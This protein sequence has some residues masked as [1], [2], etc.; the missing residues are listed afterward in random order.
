MNCLS[1]RDGCE[2][3]QPDE[4]NVSHH[5]R[6]ESCATKKT[7]DRRR[8][9]ARRGEILGVKEI[10]QI[11]FPDQRLDTVTL[12][13]SHYP[14]GKRSPMSSGRILCIASMAETLL[15]I[16]SCSFQAANVAF[17]PLDGWIEDVY[18][19]YTAR[20]TEW[21]GVPR[22]F[23]PDTWIDITDTLEKKIEAFL[24]YH[25]EVRAYRI[26]GLRKRWS[27][28]QPLFGGTSAPWKRLRRLMTVRSV[29]R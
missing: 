27:M 16:I 20:S 12:T 7:W 29:K 17:R 15:W 10:R 25:S 5:V 13:E 22:T 19:F 18:A 23:T 8:R 11:G 28:R 9:S 6:G 14:A 26:P 1:R 21:G 4:I 3:R 2:A 24:S